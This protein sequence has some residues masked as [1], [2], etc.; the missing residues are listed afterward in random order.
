[1]STSNDTKVITLAN[2][3]T[4]DTKIKE[5]LNNKLDTVVF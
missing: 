1:M 5:L 4:Y 3:T 2:I